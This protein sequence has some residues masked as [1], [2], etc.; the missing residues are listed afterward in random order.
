MMTNSVTFQRALS[1][2]LIEV[3]DGPPG[4]EAFILNP[5]D[6]GLLPRLDELSAEEASTRPM[7]GATTIA[8]HTDH[9]CYG[10][11]LMKRWADGDPN[12]WSEA[13]WSASWKRAEVT[14]DQWKELREQLRNYTEAWQ[15]HVAAREDW[16]DMEAAGALASLAHTAYHLG[17]I[18]Q[19]MA[20]L[21]K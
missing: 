12:P 5:G 9:V 3:F 6:P 21:G 18:R 15:Q 19:I 20:A 17:A 2:L 14:E 4:Q 13:D 1:K 8:S 7:P 11:S 10:F 16:N